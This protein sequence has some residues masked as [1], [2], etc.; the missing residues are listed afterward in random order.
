MDV[1][2]N[3]CSSSK[4]IL[5]VI[6]FKFGVCCGQS[7]ISLLNNIAESQKTKRNER[8]GKGRRIS[9]MMFP[10]EVSDNQQVRCVSRC[11]FAGEGVCLCSSFPSSNQPSP[12]CFSIVQTRWWQVTFPNPFSKTEAK[13]HNVILIEKEILYT[14]NVRLL[15][16]S[17]PA[18][19]K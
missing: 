13:N 17:S 19:T 10:N 14:K 15:H 12:K 3:T 7:L 16:C 18:I 2:R 8:K 1:S 11:S 6:H 4:S 9:Q 5:L